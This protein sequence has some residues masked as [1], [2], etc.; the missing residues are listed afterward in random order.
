MPAAG[1][2]ARSQDDVN[3]AH[4]AR[5]FELPLACIAAIATFRGAAGVRDVGCASATASAA[6]LRQC[7][8]DL[9]DFTCGM[10]L[11]AR[12]AAEGRCP[13]S[14]GPC[15]HHARGF[16]SRSKLSILSD[17]LGTWRIQHRSATSE[18]EGIPLDQQ[19]PAPAH[20]DGDIGRL[21]K[22]WS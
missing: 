3:N 2:A 9:G 15:G 14:F 19:C 16:D 11:I 1:L 6:V 17:A 4:S 12:D 18:D 20:T 7:A 22:M 13:L 5:G 8:E 21:G 10:V